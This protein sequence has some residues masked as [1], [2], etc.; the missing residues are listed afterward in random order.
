MKI[1]GIISNS[2]DLNKY[3]LEHDPE[4]QQE[5]LAVSRILYVMLMSTVLNL[6]PY[7]LKN[8][9]KINEK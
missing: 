3:Y 9:E 1:R 4:Q 7:N 5:I 2:L 8:N 6:K